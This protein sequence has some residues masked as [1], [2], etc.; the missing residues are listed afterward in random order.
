MKET[1]K[2]CIDCLNRK[3]GCHAQ[4]KEYNDLKKYFC[5]EKKK[6]RADLD[7]SDFAEIYRK[8]VE[9]KLKKRKWD[10]K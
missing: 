6:I 8:N 5:E 3:I 4:C 7:G 10:N 2:C 9:K 1:Y